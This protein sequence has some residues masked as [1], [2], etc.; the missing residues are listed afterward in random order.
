[1][2]ETTKLLQAWTAKKIFRQRTFPSSRNPGITYRASIL[3]GGALD[4]PN[5]DCTCPRFTFNKSCRHV[6]AMWNE[7]SGFTQASI[8]H[9][10]EIETKPWYKAKP[11]T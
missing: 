4:R 7:L 1:M 11:N 8:V 5:W 6:Q 2:K 3:Y 9:H 10:D